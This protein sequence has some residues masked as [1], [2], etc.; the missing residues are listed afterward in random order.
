MLNV[1]LLPFSFSSQT[2]VKRTKK[3]YPNKLF[4]FLSWIEQKKNLF[5]FLNLSSTKKWVCD[6]ALNEKK[7]QENKY[8]F[9]YINQAE[10]R[11]CVNKSAQKFFRKWKHTCGFGNSHWIPCVFCEM[12]TQNLIIIP[13]MD[14]IYFLTAVCNTFD[15]LLVWLVN[16]NRE[17]TRNSTWCIRKLLLN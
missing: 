10:I 16:K 15:H 9:M 5:K 11:L 1:F 3:K 13:C 8:G 6:E 7:Q 12:S 17:R 4:C 2:R 14:S